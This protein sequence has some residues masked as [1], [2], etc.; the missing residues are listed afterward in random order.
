MI[1]APG[2]PRIRTQPP[3]RCRASASRPVGD[4]HRNSAHSAYARAHALRSPAGVDRGAGAGAGGAAGLPLYRQ[5]CRFRRTVVYWYWDADHVEIGPAGA[6]LRRAHVC[7]RRGAQPGTPVTS[8]SSVATRGRTAT[9]RRAAPTS[10]STPASPSK[11][12]GARA[13]TTGSPCKPQRAP[14]SSAI[15]AAACRP[16]LPR[17]A[18]DS[19]RSLRRRNPRR[20]RT[21]ARGAGRSAP[22][23]C[24]RSLRRYAQRARR[25]RDDHQHL[26]LSDRAHALLQ[27]RRRRACTTARQPRG[28]I[29]R[30]PGPRHLARA[31]G[32]PA[33]TAQGHQRGGMPG[34][35]RIGVSAPRGQRQ[36]RLLLI[37]ARGTS[38]ETVIVA[39]RGCRNEHRFSGRP[40]GTD[41]G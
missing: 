30:Q 18:A 8:R 39:A 35:A 41:W 32:V 5:P 9:S 1:R 12:S 28:T 7:A 20:A 2:F 21:A 6:E 34:R 14:P 13:A 38:D 3:H 10:P 22:L 16:R 25:R 27:G 31:A 19:P 24:L 26:R 37:P 36:E 11:R 17:R 33:R 4:N 23:R 29:R 15:A 40:I